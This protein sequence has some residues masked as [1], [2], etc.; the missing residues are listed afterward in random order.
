MNKLGDFHRIMKIKSCRKV[1]AKI[2]TV[3]KMV[4]SRIHSLVATLEAHKS[5]SGMEKNVK[6]NKWIQ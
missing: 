1:K 6:N 2:I 4:K 5:E 3:R